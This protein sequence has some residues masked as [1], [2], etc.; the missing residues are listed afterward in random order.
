MPELTPR[1]YYFL[2]TFYRSINEGKSAESMHKDLLEIFPEYTPE[3]E[4]AWGEIERMRG[5]I[6]EV[7]G[8]G[9]EKGDR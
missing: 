6:F 3:I 8:R 2:E 5:S 4:A 7:G 1:A 9:P